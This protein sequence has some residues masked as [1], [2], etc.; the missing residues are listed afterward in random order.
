[1]NPNQFTLKLQEAFQAGQSL[2]Q[3]KNHAELQSA[4][5]LLPLLQDEGGVTRPVFSKIGAN[6]R[7]PD[8]RGRKICRSTS[9]RPG[10]SR[11][12]NVYQ[13]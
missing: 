6:S 7:F 2:A 10:V 13:W 4:H 12:T 8:P 9:F 11:S 1:M 5:I 3:E